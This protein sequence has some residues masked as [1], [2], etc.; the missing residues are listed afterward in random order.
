VG[1]INMPFKT[2]KQILAYNRKY[3][4]EH[5]VRS[6]EWSRKAYRKRKKSVKKYWKSPKG[7][8]CHSRSVAKHRKLSWN[9]SFKSYKKLI[10][11]PCYYCGISLLNQSGVSLDRINNTYGYS[12]KNVV[13]ACGTCNES[14]LDHFTVK[15]FKVMIDAVL[16]YRK[17]AK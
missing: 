8:F 6:R 14:R 11:K 3:R 16:R 9:I 5:R 15:E 7:K 4:R 1:K 12:L 10:E 2:Y 13:P 17:W